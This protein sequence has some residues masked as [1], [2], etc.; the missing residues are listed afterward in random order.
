LPDIV[1]NNPFFSGGILGIDMILA[2][3]EHA[4]FLLTGNGALYIII[5]SILPVSII[6]D[7]I[8][9]L[10]LKYRITDELFLKFR[11]HY[12][13]LDTWINDYSKYFPEIKC[14]NIDN[15]KFE[16]LMLFEIYR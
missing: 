3:L 12:S 16:K 1:G 5:T 10:Q 14:Y 7:K 11:E 2:V 4:A 9:R 13:K 15:N 6:I 8:K